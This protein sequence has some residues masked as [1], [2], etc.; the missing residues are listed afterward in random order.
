MKVE[1]SEGELIRLRKQIA[2]P[3][4]DR[5]QFFKFREALERIRNHDYNWNTTPADIA[6]DALDE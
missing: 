2:R 4:D 6:R 3:E 1:F 5:T